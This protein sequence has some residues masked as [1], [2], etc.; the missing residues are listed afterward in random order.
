MIFNFWK[1]KKNK[2]KT[3][4]NL[5]GTATSV[6][7]NK[8]AQPQEQT[9][10]FL[11]SFIVAQA[12]DNMALGILVGGDV[13]GAALGAMSAEELTPSDNQTLEDQPT[14]NQPQDDEPS[15]DSGTIDNSAPDIGSD[16][17]NDSTTN[18]DDSTTNW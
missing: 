5:T 8:A 2:K 18:F 12:T 7:S 16:S 10:D 4:N 1:R 3:S 17:L 6:N 15:Y 14:Y 11:T 13:S 9:G